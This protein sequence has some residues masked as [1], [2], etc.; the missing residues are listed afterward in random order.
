MLV[1]VGFIRDNPDDSIFSYEQ[2]DLNFQNLPMYYNMKRWVNRRG[3]DGRLPLST[4]VTRSLKWSC[5]NEIFK[6]NMPAINE[7]DIL[8]GLPLFMLAAATTDRPERGGDIELIYNL[9]KEYP[10]AMIFV[11]D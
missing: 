9:L 6:L 7:I 10:S 8:T 3:K 11:K 5:V 4:A 1:K 2:D